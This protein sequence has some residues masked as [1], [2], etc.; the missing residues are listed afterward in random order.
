MILATRLSLLLLPGSLGD[1]VSLLQTQTDSSKSLRSDVAI[2][3][4]PQN[5]SSAEVLGIW[6]MHASVSSPWCGSTRSINFRIDR[7]TKGRFVIDWFQWGVNDTLAWLNP[8]VSGTW[9]AVDLPIGEI[10]LEPI[11]DSPNLK[12]QCRQYRSVK[13]E[14]AAAEQQVSDIVSREM[15][16]LVVTGIA[17]CTAATLVALQQPL[18]SLFTIRIF[19]QTVGTEGR[20]QCIDDIRLVAVLLMVLYHALQSLQRLEA[21]RAVGLQFFLHGLPIFVYCSGRSAYLSE[22]GNPG[23]AAFVGRRSLRLLVPA[24]CGWIMVVL[25]TQ[26]L[27]RYWRPCSPAVD[28]PWQWLLEYFNPSSQN[29]VNCDGLGWLGFLVMLFLLQVMLH[30]WAVAIKKGERAAAVR[31]LAILATAA[32]LCCL[33]LSWHPPVRGGPHPLLPVLCLLPSFSELVLVAA[34][35]PGRWRPPHVFWIC[36]IVCR[37]LCC[38]AMQLGLTQIHFDEFNQSTG[39]TRDQEGVIQEVM[40]LALFYSQGFLDELCSQ[41]KV[42]AVKGRA[43]VALFVLVWGIVLPSLCLTP[44]PGGDLWRTS[45]RYPTYNG[46]AGAHFVLRTWMILGV[47]FLWWR[48]QEWHIPFAT[49][50]FPFT[51][52]VVHW[53]PL[54]VVLGFIYSRA[55]GAPLRSTPWVIALIAALITS[56][57]ITAIV[58]RILGWLFPQ[59]SAKGS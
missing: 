18:G 37:M 48:Y 11:H 4:D 28:D 27:G 29:G 24:I 3:V 36:G 17:L 45:P 32:V 43:A 34:L 50:A 38:S 54:D 13:W 52:Y 44:V 10:M 2:S 55:P 14:V 33:L 1:H 42:R 8:S 30:P 59:G 46:V 39:L 21:F 35:E 19:E 20:S 31:A 5:R 15:L 22:A 51:L 6:H 56:I 7:D 16:V 9:S 12:V 57:G 49:T 53:L 58:Q 25:P 40:I 23:F 26:Y 41:G 47:S